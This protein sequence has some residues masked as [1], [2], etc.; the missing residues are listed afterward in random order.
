MNEF[1]VDDF[2]YFINSEDLRERGVGY[3]E[4]VCSTFFGRSLRCSDSSSE[5]LIVRGYGLF[6]SSYEFFYGR[7]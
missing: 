6:D 5:S 2:L 1:E 3:L 7:C 4:D